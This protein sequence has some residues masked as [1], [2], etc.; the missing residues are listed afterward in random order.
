MKRNIDRRE[1]L[2]TAA[3]AAAVTSGIGLVSG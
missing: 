2:K 1:F 3:G